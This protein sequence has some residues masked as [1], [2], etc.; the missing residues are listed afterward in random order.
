MIFRIGIENNN[1]DRS[2]AWA[3]EHPGCFAYGENSEQAQ[4]NF[5][6]AA[7]EYAAWIARHGESWLD[8]EVEVVVEEIFDAYFIHPTF[9]RG[10]RAE[11]TYMVESFF[12][13]DW[14]PLKPHEIERALQLLAWS[15]ADLLDLV[16]DLSAEKLAQTYPDERWP[17]QG[18]LK[19]IGGAEWWYQERIG[20]PYPDNEADVPADPFERL[21][22]VRDHFNSLLPRLDGVNRVVGLEG[23]IWSPRK[24]LRRALWHERDHTEHIRKLLES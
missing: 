4:K 2:I 8:E 1:D 9:E 21:A 10:E 18:I 19:H 17:I 7:R 11:D 24:V 12:V 13:R 16:K 15:R 23:E 22:V 5:P 3:L 14:K 20:Y 6:Q